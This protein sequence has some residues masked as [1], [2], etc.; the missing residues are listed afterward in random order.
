M[1]NECTGKDL[2]VTAYGSGNGVC[3]HGYCIRLT[4][5]PWLLQIALEADATKNSQAMVTVQGRRV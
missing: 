4:L 2:H 3:C 5:S 1:Q